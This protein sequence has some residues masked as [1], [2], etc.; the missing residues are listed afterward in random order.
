VICGQLIDFGF[1]ARD[2][3]MS[4]YGNARRRRRVL[5]RIGGN[6]SCYRRHLYGFRGVL[7][8][9]FRAASGNYCF[10]SGIVYSRFYGLL[11][12]Y[13]VDCRRRSCCRRRRCLGTRIAHQ[14]GPSIRDSSSRL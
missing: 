8:G 5:V 12:L 3:V 2:S 13:G 1:D 10:C 4:F 9:I 7:C 14:H 11:V 6:G